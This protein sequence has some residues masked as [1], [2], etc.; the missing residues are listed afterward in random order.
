MMITEK[1]KQILSSII[2]ELQVMVD[3]DEWSLDCP[4]ND[5][6]YVQQALSAI[7]FKNTQI[8]LLESI[9]NDNSWIKTETFLPPYTKDTPCLV[10]YRGEVTILWW[11]AYYKS[12]D[13]ID[14]DDH[15]CDADEVEY[16]MPLPE[17]PN[18]D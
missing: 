11:N 17:R 5:P 3:A 18:K 14:G 7:K 4:G 12:W 10:W 1:D 16:W 15:E 2:D 9:M 6:D 8:H 13:T